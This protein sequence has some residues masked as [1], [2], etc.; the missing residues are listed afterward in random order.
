MRV[1]HLDAGGTRPFG[2]R[3]FDG[4]PGVWREAAGACHCLLLEHSTGLTLVDTGYGEQA[5]VRPEVWVG[6]QLIRQSN[7]VL[8]QPIA[9]QV[10]AL[11]FSRADV[12]DIVVTHLD[13]DHAGGLADFPQ[14]TVHVYRAELDTVEGPYGPR[15]KFRYRSVHFEHGPKWSVYDESDSRAERW[16]GFRAVREL[17]GLSPEI[18]MVPLTGHTRGHVGV[19]VDTGNGWLLHAGDA[20]T[21]HGQMQE[22]PSMPLGVRAFQRYVDTQR[23]SRIENQ[24]RLR[25]LVR[26]NGDEVTVFSAHCATEFERLHR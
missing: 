1:H 26:D 6:R 13:L 4:R 9:R 16:F 12:R 8:D 11:G 10:E 14:A 18:L 3:L 20:Y 2:G 15:E 17:R 25:E 24:Q 19:A 7:P 21:Y 22:K 5:L 23:R